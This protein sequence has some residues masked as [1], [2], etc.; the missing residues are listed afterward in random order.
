[1]YLLIVTGMSGA[2]KTLALRS[3][4]ELGYYCVDNLPSPM[5]A[6]FIRMCNSAVPPVEKAA[7]TIDS[8]ESLLS[9]NSRSVVDEIRKITV[10]YQILFL[11]A[12]TEVLRR[13]YS[14]TRRRHPLGLAGEAESGVESERKYL[15]ELRDI[16]GRIIDTSDV[17]ARDFP[18]MIEKILPEFSTNEMSLIVSSFGYKRGV[19]IDADFVID[20]RFAD[21]PFYYEEMRPLSG[22]DKKVYDF[23]MDQPFVKEY[24]ENLKQNV[25]DRRCFHRT[26]QR[27]P[28]A[29]CGP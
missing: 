4:E 16:A 2:G 15:R 3:V 25:L 22:L 8:R 28:F 13:R 23:V 5:L 21:N 12:R 29:C 24:L 20:M 14:E 11:D 19:P 6:E 17:S 26:I 10:P 1:M 18:H 9:R 7:V 27:Y